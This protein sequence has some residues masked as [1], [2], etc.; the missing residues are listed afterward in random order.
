MLAVSKS[1]AAYLPL[2]P[3]NPPHRLAFMLD[4]AD[5][6][7][8]ITEKRFLDLLP[9]HLSTICLDRDQALIDQQ[10]QQNLDNVATSQNAVYVVYTSGSTGTPKGILVEHRSLVNECLAFASHHRLQTGDRLLQFA[11]PGFD[12]AAEEVFAPLVCGATIVVGH[13]KSADSVEGLIERC[14]RE[15]V[16]VLNLPSAYW[17][18]WVSQM[19]EGEARLADSLRLVIVGNERVRPERYEAWRRAVGG[20]IE[21]KNAYGPT[22]ATITTT[23]YRAEGEL[24]SESVPIGRPITNAEVYI[25]DE[26]MNPVPVGVVGQLHIGGVGLARGYVK[27]AELT[28]ESFI[29]HPF[30]KEA[31]ARLYRTGDEARYLEDGEIEFIGRRDE[32]VKV[33]GY[34]VELGEVEGVLSEHPKVREAVVVARGG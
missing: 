1:G 29:A 25:L 28:A 9:P 32:Q 17:H 30:S 16:S 13:D 10:P 18:E 6:H 12:V 5:A 15:R 20:R 23:I 19:S 4:D 14:Q 21:W 27:R 26:E 3:S 7:L 34:R 24:R 33:R 2:D 11:S 31:G 22:E 8:V